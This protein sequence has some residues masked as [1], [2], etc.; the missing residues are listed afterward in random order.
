MVVNIRGNVETR[1]KK[2]M[3]GDVDATILA[4]AGLIRLG[5]FDSKNSSILEADSFIPAVGQGVIAIEALKQNAHLYKA[6]NHE[7]TY[8]M[9]S[10]ERE[11]LRNLYADCRTP[12][13]CYARTQDGE[14]LVDYMFAE[15]VNYQ[16]QTYRYVCPVYD[17]NKA[18]AHSGFVAKT[19]KSRASKDD[20]PDL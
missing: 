12:A 15:D 9:I 11:F 17:I 2:V 18:I 6:L 13:G 4:G 1:I 3:D 7:Y 19:I 20:I 10:I 8:D 5:L 16:V 14:L